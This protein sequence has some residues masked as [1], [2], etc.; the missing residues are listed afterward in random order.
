MK[1]DLNPDTEIENLGK[2]G[3]PKT[4]GVANGLRRGS[5]GPKGGSW[6]LYPKGVSRA[7]QRRSMPT[8]LTLAFE[9][10]HPL[11]QVPLQVYT[12]LLASEHM[13]FVSSAFAQLNA[14]VSLVM[15]FRA[16][17]VAAVVVPGGVLPVFH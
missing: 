3:S 13:R 10:C 11:P 14:R 6:E 16:A 8:L 12:C 17:C 5:Q 2:G 15:A 9:P 1:N 7:A 4:E